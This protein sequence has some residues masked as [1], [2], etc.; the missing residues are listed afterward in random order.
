M[1]TTAGRSTWLFAV[2]PALAFIAI[3]ADNPYPNEV[4][5]FKLFDTARWRTV[6]PLVTTE[7]DVRSLLGEP[8]PVLFD[9]GPDWEFIIYYWS[10]GTCDGRPYPETLIGKVASIEIIPRAP[11]SFAKVTFPSVFRKSDLHSSHDP[12]GSWDVYSDGS[13]LQYQIYRQAS[14]D[15]KIRAHDLKSIVYGPSSETYVRLTNCPGSV[16]GGQVE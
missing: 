4:P 5:G 9:G 14:S 7:A 16:P 2:I 1:K 6:R 12:V 13:G 8:D 10:G 3:A 11:L 15:G